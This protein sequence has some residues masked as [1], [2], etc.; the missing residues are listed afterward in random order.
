MAVKWDIETFT[1]ELKKIGEHRYHHLHPFSARMNR[2][3]LS[4]EEI[5]S[6]IGNRFYYQIN[7]PRKDAAIIA[8]CPVRE[9][10][11]TWLHRLSDHDGMAAGEGGIENW[12]RL[13]ASAG[14]DE[15]SLWRG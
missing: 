7:L 1:G 5:R 4:A 6:W 2:G 3:Q 11:R 15:P 14:L 13:G 8:N 12:I 10:R 9:V